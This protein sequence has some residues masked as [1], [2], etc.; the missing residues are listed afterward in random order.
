VAAPL[1]AR[2]LAHHGL[3]RPRFTTAA[4]VVSWYGAVQGQEFGPAKWGIAQRTSTLANSDLDRAFDAGEILRTH[5]LRPTWHFVAPA[6]IRW[7]QM[8]TAPRVR[9]AGGSI[10]RTLALTPRVLARG[11]DAIARALAGGTFLTRQE[12]STV[13]ARARIAAKGQRLAYIVMHAE[14][15]AVICS[16]PRRGKQFTYALVAERAKKTP[17]L[18][19]EEALRELTVRYFR[20]HGPATVRD[21]VWWS[22]LRVADARAGIALAGLREERIGG[23]TC[24]SLDQ[25]LPA[26]RSTASVRLLPIYDEYVVAYRDRDA[27][28]TR[29][30]GFDMWGSYVVADGRL[31]GS[32]RAAG[33]AVSLAPGLPLD[34]RHAALAAREVNRFQRFMRG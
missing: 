15:E 27:I 2:R 13:L 26:P 30:N 8:L 19:R 6:D 28:A 32:W 34:T 12:L 4:D 25:H 14:L 23:L 16:G 10:Y 21:F 18:T 29:M 24:W 3:A 17:A 1:I 7:M 31:V 5:I 33:D 22:S 9:A 20:S 11:I